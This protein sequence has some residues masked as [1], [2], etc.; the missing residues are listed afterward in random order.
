MAIREEK[1][2]KIYRE[3]IGS[4]WKITYNLKYLL[5]V[6]F[7]DDSGEKIVMQHISNYVT[8]A[9]CQL[10]IKNSIIYIELISKVIKNVYKN[11]KI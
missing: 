10:G 8:T 4:D 1:Y 9:I 3:N 5:Y 6:S 2:D 7:V 11:Y